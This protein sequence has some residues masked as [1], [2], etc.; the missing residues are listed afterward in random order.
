MSSVARWNR[1]IASGSPGDRSG[2]EFA[3][4]LGSDVKRA[5]YFLSFPLRGERH[6]AGLLT[7]PILAFSLSQI[8]LVIHYSPA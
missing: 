1:Q 7:A 2:V 3:E 8:S 6:L 5:N 4:F